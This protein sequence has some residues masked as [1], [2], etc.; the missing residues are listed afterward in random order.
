VA[1][2]LVQLVVLLLLLVLEQQ[3]LVLQPASASVLSS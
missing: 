1:D 2:V 3:P